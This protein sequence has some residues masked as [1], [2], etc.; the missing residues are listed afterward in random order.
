MTRSER[1]WWPI[2]NLSINC[3]LDDTTRWGHSTTLTLLPST[4]MPIIEFTN[5]ETCRLSSF[6]FGGM[7]HSLYLYYLSC[8]FHIRNENSWYEVENF[9]P[10]NEHTLV[11]LLYLN[12]NE[13]LTQFA[14]DHPPYLLCTASRRWGHRNLSFLSFFYYH[15]ILLQYSKNSMNRG[16]DACDNFSRRLRAA[17]WYVQCRRGGGQC[18]GSWLGS[19]PDYHP[20]EFEYRM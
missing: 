17:G 6:S 20:P 8:H 4:T 9:H 19:V 7:E 16:R 15:L 18:V 12:L 10:A 3:T 5:A 11:R 14:W 2:W 1:G 13:L